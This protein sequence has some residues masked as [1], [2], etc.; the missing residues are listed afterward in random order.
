MGRSQESFGKKE[1]DKKRLKK[2]K[3]KLQ[4]K[5]ERKAN[6]QGGDLDSMIAYV[7]ENGNI[8]D[9]PPDPTTKSKIKAENIEVSVPKKEKEEVQTIRTGKVT[10][11]NDSKGFGFIRDLDSQE[12]I[13][14]HVHGLLE[15]VMENDKV[16]FEI[17]RGFKGL[18]AVR[19]KKV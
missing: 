6:S 14:F 2:R 19:V 17:E 4:K 18:N 13:F 8:T 1:K 5:E 15:D 12:K 16:T 9:T 7:D 3:D 10:F 11:F